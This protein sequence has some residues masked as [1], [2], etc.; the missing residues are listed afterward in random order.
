VG[1]AR[2]HALLGEKEQAMK[3]LREG[4]AEMGLFHAPRLRME[5]DLEPLWGYP[6]FEELLRPKV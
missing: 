1:R 6:P 2:I 3:V 4:F 5:M